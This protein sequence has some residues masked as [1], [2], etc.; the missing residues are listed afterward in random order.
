MFN[1]FIFFNKVP[2]IFFRIKYI[3]IIKTLHKIELRNVSKTHSN[4]LQIRDEDGKYKPVCSCINHQEWSNNAI[5][6]LI[7]MRKSS[8]FSANII[9]KMRKVGFISAKSNVL[10]TEGYKKY[11]TR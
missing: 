8:L 6:K 7:N 10:C 5:W 3:E 9:K 2:F 4:S 1:A 11:K